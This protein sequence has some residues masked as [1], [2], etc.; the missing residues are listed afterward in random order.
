MN[1]MKPTKPVI[2][3]GV[4]ANNDI[5]IGNYFG[6][7]LPI[8]NMAKRRSADFDIN[9][10][11]PDLHSFTTPIDHSKLY[12]SILNNARIY[13][14]AG[15]PLDNE[16]IH[17]YRQSRV[18][19]HSELAWILDCFTGFGEMER[20]TQFKDKSGRNDL[21]SRLTEQI[22]R[23]SNEIRSH[24]IE[25]GIPARDIIDMLLSERKLTLP[26][27]ENLYNDMNKGDVISV[28]LFNYPV[29]MAADILLYGATYVPVGDDQTQHL[30]F[31]RDIA[32][33][34][35]RKFGDLFVVPKP[36][37]QQHQFFGNDQ[38]LRIKDLMNPTKKMSK[39]DD[40]GKG[41]IFL[42]DEP[43]VAHKKIMSAT[44]DSLGKVQ[45]DR[46]NQPGISNLL[47]ILTLVR[48]DAGQDVGLE[49]TI[50]EY[51]GMERY[52][53]FKRIV[54][55]EV[56]E[57]LANF[58][59]RLAAVDEPAIERKLESS[60]RDMNIVANETLHRVQTAV[61]LRR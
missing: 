7:I 3:T 29:L 61:G 8:V 1:T 5:H 37:A 21:A 20:M 26:F 52:G 25:P 28:G 56:A 33:R 54:A 10:F 17:L 11:I 9:L 44:T 19:A 46:E 27:L 2:L 41:V 42:G 35:N 48:Q 4:R 18:P 49:Q 60:E 6:A 59:A 38:G 51:A 24:Q 31:T 45:Y 23:L 50:S 12:D 32:E 40:S 57:F 14:A 30:E 47:E 53:D 13:T 58:Q 34:M 36:V 55:D 43:G 16:A 39:S 15:L 22:E